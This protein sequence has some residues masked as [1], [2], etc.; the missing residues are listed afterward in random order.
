M[1][2]NQQVLF[3]DERFAATI[4]EPMLVAL[5][6]FVFAFAHVDIAAGFC[7]RAA[8]VEI[9]LIETG[10]LLQPHDSRGS[11]CDAAIS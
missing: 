11:A 2:K 4:S 8:E 1:S 3:F 9:V 10:D 7:R 6:A 5:S